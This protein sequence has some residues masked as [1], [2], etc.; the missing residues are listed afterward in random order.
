MEIHHAHLA[1]EYE[2]ENLDDSSEIEDSDDPCDIDDPQ[3]IGDPDEIDQI[4]IAALPQTQPK[5]FTGIEDPTI[6]EKRRRAKRQHATYIRWIE[7]MTR[8]QKEALRQYRRVNNR[9]WR[10]RHVE[11]IKSDEYRAKMRE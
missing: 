4:E 1:V 10:A 7:K 3:T 6:T 2:V 8:E 11:R 9:D 5:S